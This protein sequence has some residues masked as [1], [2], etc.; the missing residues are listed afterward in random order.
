MT[1]IVHRGKVSS[2]HLS[3]W[4]LSL[5]SGTNR[6]VVSNG[7]EQLKALHK[8]SSSLSKTCLKQIF[9]SPWA[10]SALQNFAKLRQSP[11]HLQTEQRTSGDNDTRQP[12]TFLIRVPASKTSTA[13][14]EQ[15][16]KR[17]GSNATKKPHELSVS[18]LAQAFANSSA[19]FPVR[20]VTRLP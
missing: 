20:E 10:A 9:P 1:Q 13:Q 11:K 16:Y 7:P 6:C 4:S 18:P 3:F 15:L 2:Y 17:P 5:S 14:H 19:T 8:S 12:K